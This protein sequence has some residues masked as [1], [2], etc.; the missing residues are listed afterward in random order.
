MCDYIN[1]FTQR[2]TVA[3]EK[4]HSVVGRALG[5]GIKRRKNVMGFFERV[6]EVVKR[7]PK[8]K[9]TTY[10][11]VA[12]MAGNPRMARYVGYAL[13][14]NPQP[15]IIPCHRVVNRYGELSG[16]FAFGGADVQRE[17]LEAEGVAVIGN[18]VDLKEYYWSEA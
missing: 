3:W 17:L 13:H 9:V 11:S 18:R 7:I 8:G 12:A 2:S 4:K 15:I 6:Y 10:G 5:N 14:V 1:G 16:A